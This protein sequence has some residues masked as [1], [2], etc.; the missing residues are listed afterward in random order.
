MTIDAITYLKNAITRIDSGEVSSESGSHLVG[1]FT[2]SANG[3]EKELKSYVTGLL[4]NSGI[5][6][7]QEIRS[8]INGPP[9]SKATLGQLIIVL[10]T[11]AK[12]KP[13]VVSKLTPAKS[14]A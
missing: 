1:I 5:D 4:Q 2:K 12:L 8:A 3:F 11:A 7:E 9:F 13:K 10:K 6:Y 14:L